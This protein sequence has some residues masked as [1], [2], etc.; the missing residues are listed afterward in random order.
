[1]KFKELKIFVSIII[2]KMDNGSIGF[3]IL[4]NVLLETLKTI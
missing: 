2:S 4:S 1:M 3:R